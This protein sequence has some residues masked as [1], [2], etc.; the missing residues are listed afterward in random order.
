MWICQ[1]QFERKAT[2]FQ[3]EA[4][5]ENEFIRILTTLGYEYIKIKNEKEISKEMVDYVI[6]H[7]VSSKAEKVVT[8]EM[9]IDAVSKLFRVNK[10]EITSK[11]KTKEIVIPRQ[12]SIYLCKNLTE[13]SFN[14]IGEYFGGKDH[15]TV[16]HAVKKVDFYIEND[17]YIK[18]K[19]E[20]LTK[21]LKNQ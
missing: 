4:E 10:E 5:L 14:K 20:T 8:P 9:I 6:E 11:R 21:N 12:I 17:P 16:M 1:Y 19:V 13:L 18:E 15:S 3:S 2:A 7:Y